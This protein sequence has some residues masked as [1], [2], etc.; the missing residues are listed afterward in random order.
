MNT[1]GSAPSRILLDTETRITSIDGRLAGELGHGAEDLLEG[2]FSAII[3]PDDL[4]DVGK[5]LIDL[6]T[7]AK[8][9]VTARRQL[10]RAD[11]ETVEVVLSAEPRPSD[12]GFSGFAVAV[13][14]DAD[15]HTPPVMPD[16]LRRLS[17]AAALI[18]AEGSIV[19][20]NLAWGQLFASPGAVA[21]GADVHLLV[22]EDERDLL[23]ARVGEVV[24][25]AAT[26]SRL[27]LRCLADGES[28]WCRLSLAPFDSSS[29]HL[30]ITAE[31]ISEQ[32]LT[33]RV[34]T[35]NEALFRSLAESSPVGL[36]RLAP[37]L[38]ITY[39]S[40]SW[41]RVTGEDETQPF[42]D[43]AAIIH[44]D[45]RDDALASCRARIAAGSAEPVVARLN[46]DDQTT[47]WASLRLG[48]VAD[49][50]VGLIGYVVTVE[51]V[52]DIVTASESQGQLA[53]VIES[54]SDLVGIADLRTGN[55]LYLNAAAQDQFGPLTDEPRHIT[56]LYA[57]GA[58]DF[59][60]DEVYPVL[61]R[62]ETWSGDLE[63]VRRDGTTIRVRQTVAV[64]I[65]PDGEPER[66]S[67]LGRDVSD[68]QQALDELAYKATHDALTGLPN[69]SLLVDHLE[70]ALARS[71][72]DRRPVGVLFVDLD[73]FKIVNDTYG[74]DAGDELLRDL[75]DRMEAVLRPSDTVAR[76]GGDEFVVLCED[77]DG[78]N[79]ALTIAERI[80]TAIEDSPFR[81]QGVDLTVGAS[82]GIA[83]SNGGS[84]REP[85]NLL[86]RADAAMYRAKNA[87]RGRT[88]LFDDVRRDRAK[89]RAEQTDQLAQAIE[90]GALEVHYQ[91]IVDLQTGRVSG[92]EAL[93]RWL[94]PTNGLL[95]PSEFLPLAIETG[96]AADLD[97]LV[98]GRAAADAAA[99][100]ER[101]NGNG[102]RVHVNVDGT[103]LVSGRLAEV[104]DEA[105]ASTGISPEKLCVELSEPFMMANGDEIVDQIADIRGRNVLIA[106]D[107]VGTGATQL[108]RLGRFAVDILKID[109]T[110]TADVLGEGASRPLV[111]GIVGLAK[112][113]GLE[114][115]AECVED[116]AA[117]PVM[118]ELGVT[119]AQ[120]HVFSAALPAAK[121]EQLLNLRSTLARADR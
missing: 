41:R 25:G 84:S 51:E 8:V 11:G 26:S 90:D 119:V 92:V 29:D 100:Q 87:G 54:T 76:L 103:T 114:V 67:V 59:Y 5:D 102:P 14:M 88:E 58:L 97:A 48:E 37:D 43:L 77:I 73:R 56:E 60:R 47:R 85:A 35:A 21:P 70:L 120:G 15:D 61:R 115:G 116:A 105:V 121:A 42:L 9:V 28:F 94:H 96:M 117:I 79:D 36:A 101:F 109:G 19:D 27:E 99:W 16:H 74:H 31:D 83:I 69:R 40:P 66:A 3:A 72:R 53:G 17:I 91:P 108:P 104:I 52:T 38:A 57:A 112:A 113:L 98:L 71:A 55:L 46:D 78:E 81:F 110:V 45:D 80:R 63:M 12:D 33:T 6:I 23:Q 93:V 30:T 118:R 86:Q 111:A 2:P 4:T 64:E 32:H 39:A 1:Y 68:E 20:T 18:D 107:D 62:G 106:I 50:E 49:A 65:G 75:A 95:G 7:G 13:L 82:I 22:H 44:P 10:L 34:L 89:R 24:R